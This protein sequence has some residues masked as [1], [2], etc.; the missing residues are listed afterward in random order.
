MSATTGPLARARSVAV[1]VPPMAPI[2]AGPGS[3][4]R[5]VS[6]RVRRALKRVFV[7]FAGP[8]V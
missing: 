3:D 6:I 7:L 1:A 8:G 4:R 2:F 5:R